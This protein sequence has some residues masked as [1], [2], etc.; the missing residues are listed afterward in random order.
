MTVINITVT[1]NYGIVIHYFR[2][3]HLEK[4]T[5]KYL[6]TVQFQNFGHS[7][8]HYH[9]KGTASTI[10]SDLKKETTQFQD[11]FDSLHHFRVIRPERTHE[12]GARRTHNMLKMFLQ[13]QHIR[14]LIAIKILL[15][16][17]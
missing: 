17:I 11:R 5:I 16:S 13:R 14:Q 10:I 3:E 6:F 8:T 4:A 2:Q 12:L 1:L 7:I 9:E 15:C